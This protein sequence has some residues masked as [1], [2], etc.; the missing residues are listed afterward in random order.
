MLEVTRQWLRRRWKAS[1]AYWL[2][3][4]LWWI[5][6]RGRALAGRRQIEGRSRQLNEEIFATVVSDDPARTGVKSEGQVKPSLGGFDVGDV[7]L[8]ELARSIWRRHL[9]QPVFRDLVIVATVGGAG[10]KTAFLFG[11]QTLLAH[12][13]GNAV[14][15]AALAPFAQIKPN[16]RAAVGVSADREHG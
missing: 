4:S 15:S 12:E 8:P 1:A 6:S 10:P 9:G 2:P 14:L 3:R 11:T 5:R 13:P 7:A 16:A